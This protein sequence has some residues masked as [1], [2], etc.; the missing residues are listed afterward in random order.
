M[1]DDFAPKT[2]D[3]GGNPVFNLP[4]QSST[5]ESS[6]SHNPQNPDVNSVDCLLPTVRTTEDGC[7]ILESDD[8]IAPWIIDTRRYEARVGSHRVPLPRGSDD[9]MDLIQAL[10]Q[11]DLRHLMEQ[12]PPRPRP[13]KK[14]RR[15]PRGFGGES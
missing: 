15:K 12:H 6:E 7:I 4:L 1:L 11:A 5:G 3:Q 2:Q 13:R 8:G 14:Q 10:L 9:P